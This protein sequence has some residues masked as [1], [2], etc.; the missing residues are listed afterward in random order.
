MES[1]L[2]SQIFQGKLKYLV[3][4]KGYGIEEEK[5]RPS[6][7]VKGVRRLI[8]EFHKKNPEA[9]QHIF[10]IDF[11]NLPFHLLTNFM[12]TLDTVPSG[13]AMG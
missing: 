12:D 11:T 7:D 8:T 2:D 4:W 5:W 3:C 9:P 13:W 1:I 6:E 10:S